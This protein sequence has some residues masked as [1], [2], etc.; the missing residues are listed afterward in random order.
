LQ[1][2]LRSQTVNEKWLEE[3]GECLDCR[4]LSI[5][6]DEL[7]EAL[8]RAKA[9]QISTQEMQFTI[10]NDKY[11]QLKAAMD[12]STNSVYVTELVLSMICSIIC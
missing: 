5:V 6:I 3:Q 8:S 11:P 7:K 12:N 4:L 2:K 1:E 9:D 10:P